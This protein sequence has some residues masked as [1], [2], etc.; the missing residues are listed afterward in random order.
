MP[1]HMI[2]PMVSTKFPCWIIYHSLLGCLPYTCRS[3]YIISPMISIKFPC[4]AI[5]HSLLECLLYT[6]LS[7]HIIS[8]MVSTKFPCWTIYH[9]PIGLSIIYL[10]AFIDS[11]LGFV[12][13]SL[14]SVIRLMTE[15]HL[16]F[17]RLNTFF[18]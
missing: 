6:C 1:A 7:T 13:P 2:S 14:V 10:S 4:W 16:I 5:Y 18:F 15:T 11:K 17:M 3:T 9:S 8:Y 12:E